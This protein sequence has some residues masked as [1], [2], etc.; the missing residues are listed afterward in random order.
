MIKAV[1]PTLFKPVLIAAL[2]SV[3]VASIPAYAAPVEKAPPNSERLAADTLIR[4][5][6]TSQLQKLMTEEGY[7]TKVDKDGDLVWKLDGFNTFVTIAKDQESIQFYVGF[8]ADDDP[9]PMDRINEWNRGK[10]YSRTYVTEDG[11]PYLVLDLDLVGGVSKERVIDFLSTC[12]VS[13]SAWMRQ[14][15]QVE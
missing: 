1:L 12:R 14:I 2:L 8:D 15:I 13:F 6:T 3:S 4:S 7:S 10:K 11:S 9:I 5:I